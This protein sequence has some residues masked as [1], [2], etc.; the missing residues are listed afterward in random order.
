MAREDRYCSIVPGAYLPRCT[1]T[2][3]D[4][5][6]SMARHSKQQQQAA[7]KAS[8]IP[9]KYRES[10]GDRGLHQRRSTIGDRGLH[11]RRYTIRGKGF[12]SKAFYDRGQGFTSDAFY[13]RG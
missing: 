12:T 3:G 13:D 9:R 4:T 2:R 8:L 7:A 11:Q 1:I 5:A 10:I 6:G